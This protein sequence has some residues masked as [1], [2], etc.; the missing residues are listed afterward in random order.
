MGAGAGSVTTGGDGAGAGSGV[1]SGVGAG[2]SAGV[3]AVV[4][5]AAFDFDDFFVVPPA[6][7]ATV[8]STSAVTARPRMKP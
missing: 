5:A 1:G 3:G 4:F 7:G 2:V 8:S 6:A